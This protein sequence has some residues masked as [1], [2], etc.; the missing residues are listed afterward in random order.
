MNED[1]QSMIDPELE[2][3]IVAMVLGEASDFEAEQLRGM[4]DDRPE[5][6]AF[7]RELLAV[8]G[9]LRD[10]TESDST[11][12]EDWKLPAERR[13]QV[14]GAIGASHEAPSSHADSGSSHVQQSFFSKK[15]F[16]TLMAMA[17]VALFAFGFL[18]MR[19]SATR[20]SQ[21]FDAR[22]GT[23]MM[24]EVLEEG[25]AMDGIETGDSFERPFNSKSM[26]AKNAEPSD[27]PDVAMP[28]TRAF[29]SPPQE[30]DFDS[31]SR[32]DY[33]DS[34]RSVLSEIRDNLAR[35]VVPSEGG[36]GVNSGSKFSAGVS[37]E[38]ASPDAG[39]KAASD[40]MPDLFAGAVDEFR[41]S[42]FSEAD[43]SESSMPGGEER[44][45]LALPTL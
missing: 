38:F 42:A 33:F 21:L 28:A 13:S 4:I 36:L 8:D 26:L 2:V 35:T 30:A 9:L 24:Y 19:S 12:G 14:L 23:S 5:L 11:E 25:A 32:E 27:S 16:A 18:L 43:P 20:V 15:R 17:A 45:K 10:A 40:A 6:A 34:S 7:E 22:A 31:E 41:E 37:P 3:R 44:P 1:S 29:E 39:V